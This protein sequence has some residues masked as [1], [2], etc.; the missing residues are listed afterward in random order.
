[1]IN[2]FYFLNEGTKERN[3]KKKK[4]RKKERREGE[5]L[6][7]DLYQDESSEKGAILSHSVF[8]L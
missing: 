6:I 7:Q 3:K 1:M 2:S 5:F 4:K 8:L